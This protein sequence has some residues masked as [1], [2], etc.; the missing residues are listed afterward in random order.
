MLVDLVVQGNQMFIIMIV[1]AR[2]CVFMIIIKVSQSTTITGKI[3]KYFT[4]MFSYIL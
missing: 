3:N 1:E 4:F 2:N